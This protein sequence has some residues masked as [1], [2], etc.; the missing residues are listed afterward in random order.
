MKIR[1]DHASDTIE[2]ILKEK[3]GT[4]RET[5]SPFITEKVDSDGNI[6]AISVLKASTLKKQGRDLELIDV[7]QPAW[8]DFKLWYE[9][10]S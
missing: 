6:V 1:Y 3:E 10:K 8:T 7:P 4:F 2:F 5:N 9:M